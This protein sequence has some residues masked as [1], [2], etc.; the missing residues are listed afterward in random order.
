V[1]RIDSLRASIGRRLGTGM[2]R[3][4]AARPRTTRGV[5]RASLKAG[6]LVAALAVALFVVGSAAAAFYDQYGFH[7]ERNARSWAALETSYADGAICQACHADERATLDTSRHQTVSCESCHGPL[8]AHVADPVN[9]AIVIEAP[10]DT[11]CATC[12][13]S[14]S[15]KPVGFPQVELATHYRS[16]VCRA[17][18]DAHST[19]VVR[20]PEVSH[21]LDNLPACTTCHKPEGLKAL[22]A[23]HEEAADP[24]CLGCHGAGADGLHGGE[25]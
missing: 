2:D 6:V 16:G 14:S 11:L 4:R 13:A 9:A 12:H 21:P 3:L 23:G 7:P 1:K 19:A 8:G 22:P 10:P 17:C 5:V 20:P 24:V 15:G 25:R 18:H